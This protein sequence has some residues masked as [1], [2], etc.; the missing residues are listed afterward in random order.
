MA[1]ERFYEL[2][3]QF[4]EIGEQIDYTSDVA[5]L[6]VLKVL[7]A[8]ILSESLQIIRQLTQPENLN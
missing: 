5:E 1:H 3:R 7:Q 2:E 6:H 8:D 4:R